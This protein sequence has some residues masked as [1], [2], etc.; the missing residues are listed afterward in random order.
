MISF[1]TVP[2]SEYKLSNNSLFELDSS[3]VFGRLSVNN[4]IYYFAWRSDLIQPEINEITSAIFSVGID[5]KFVVYNWE[6]SEKLLDINLQSNFYLSQQLLGK[7]FIVSELD[8]TI[9]NLLK[10][11]VEKTIQLPSY[12]KNIIAKNDTVKALCLDGEI[13]DLFSL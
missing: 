5:Q 9:I 12:F 8:T 3:R 10:W 7:L 2:E 1:K 6:D 13:V 4:S 11:E